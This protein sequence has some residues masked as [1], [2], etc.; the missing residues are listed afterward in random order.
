[1]AKRKHC[2]NINETQK[3]RFRK[4][5]ESE[6]PAVYASLLLAMLESE[7]TEEDARYLFGRSQEIW[8]EH[9]TDI[10]GMLVKCYNQTGIQVMTPQQYQWAVNKGLVEGDLDNE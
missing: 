10:I 1:M 7:M 2:D 4:Q 8:A 9:T 3:Q 5:T 6:V